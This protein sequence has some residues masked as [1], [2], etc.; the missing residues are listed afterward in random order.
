[1]AVGLALLPCTA[2][3]PP[4]DVCA[5]GTR[6]GYARISPLMSGPGRSITGIT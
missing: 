2:N 3:A 1:M 6:V 5:S 4:G